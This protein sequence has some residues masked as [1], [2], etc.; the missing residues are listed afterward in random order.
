MKANEIPEE[1]RKTQIKSHEA[2]IKGPRWALASDFIETSVI[3]INNSLMK[4]GWNPIKVV[5]TKEFTTLT[6]R[7]IVFILSGEAYPV[8]FYLDILNDQLERYG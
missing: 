2:Y 3:E 8:Q 1:Q 4:K 7:T 5:S 6:T